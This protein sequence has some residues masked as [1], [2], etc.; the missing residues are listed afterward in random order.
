MTEVRQLCIEDAEEV[1]ELF[2]SAW[3]ESRRMD[4]DEIREWFDNEA[5]KRENLVVLEH[6][7]RTVGYFDVWPKAETAD[8]D[9]AAPGFWEDAFE[10]A[11]AH[12]RALGI[13]RARTFFVDGHELGEFA[14][15]RGYRVVRS[16]FTMEIELGEEP[17]VEPAVPEGIELQEY[18]HPADERAVYEAQQEA[19]ADH[20]GFHPEPVEQWRSFT[21]ESRTFDPSLWV[22]ARAGN[23]VA[24]LSLNAFERHGDPGYGWVGTLGVRRQWRRRG[25]GEA[26]L[27]RSFALLHACGQRRV[28]LSVDSENVTGATRLYERVGMHVIRRSNTWERTL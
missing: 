21:V 4:G 7:G 13:P 10:H 15:A 20:W 9:I 23:E 25:L 8:I 24:G 26:L 11:E 3:G 5:L 17:P 19:F 28:G 12:V 6:E 18:A 22:V 27:R 16:S 14:D 1:A 2:V